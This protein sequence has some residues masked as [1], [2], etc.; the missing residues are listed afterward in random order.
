[1]RDFNQEKPVIGVIG[2]S[3]EDAEQCARVICKD[4]KY[5]VRHEHSATIIETDRAIYVARY[6]GGKVCSERWDGIL[7]FIDNDGLGID[8][9]EDWLENVRWK[10][11]WE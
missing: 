5:T 4:Q 8:Y 1:M 7:F 10:A 9:M 3:L 11:K 6:K 2:E